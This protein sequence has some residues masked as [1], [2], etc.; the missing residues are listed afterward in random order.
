[1]EVDISAFEVAKCQDLAIWVDG[2]Y[3]VCYGLVGASHHLHHHHYDHHHRR[4]RRHH[5]RR[6]PHL[7]PHL[8]RLHHPRPR[9]LTRLRPSYL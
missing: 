1:V 2:T 7:H 9:H 8:R 4:P 6:R 5:H 3:A